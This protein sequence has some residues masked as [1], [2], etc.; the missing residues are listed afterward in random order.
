MTVAAVRLAG[1]PSFGQW[2]VRH[3]EEEEEIQNE[4]SVSHH[5]YVE[6][7]LDSALVTKKSVNSLFF[8]FHFEGE[9][10]SCLPILLLLKILFVVL[11]IILCYDNS[12]LLDERSA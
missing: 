10:P 6:N 2:R 1:S 8:S 12:L 11:F 7:K 3:P 9:I 5:V 4:K